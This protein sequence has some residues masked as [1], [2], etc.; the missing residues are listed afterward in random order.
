M[1]IEIPNGEGWEMRHQESHGILGNAAEMLD[2][3]RTA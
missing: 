2:S 3:R 1:R